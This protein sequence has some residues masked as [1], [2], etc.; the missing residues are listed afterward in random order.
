MRSTIAAGAIAAACMSGNVVAQNITQTGPFYLKI[1][2]S[3]NET[4]NGQY[5]GACHAGAAIEG[6]CLDTK[7][8]SGS[9]YNFFYLN[10]TDYGAGLP[11]TGTLV[12]NLPYTGPDGPAIASQSL[13]FNTGNLGSNVIVPLFGLDSNYPYIGFDDSSKAYV[14]AFDDSTLVDGQYP[15]A[16]STVDFYNWYAC[17]AQTGGYFYYS[18]AWVTSGE[19]HNPTCQSVSVV[20]E[21]VEAA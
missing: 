8:Q 14:Q 19:P 15:N 1:T 17:Y 16:S 20:R 4:I 7:A 10:Q 6:L 2:S 3:T 9:N 18:L 11:P 5:L 13:S 21:D 12:W